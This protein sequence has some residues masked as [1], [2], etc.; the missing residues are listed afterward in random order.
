MIL[1]YLI[2]VQ[3]ARGLLPANNLMTTAQSLKT[4][5]V[6]VKAIRQG[7]LHLFDQI[8]RGDQEILVRWG[9][10][11]VVERARLLVVRQLFQKSHKILHSPSRLSLDILKKA[12]SV[13][14][15]SKTSD[16]DVSCLVVN[17]INKV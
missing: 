5:A 17:L 12:V 8:F 14:T 15:K 10:W 1:R 3:M 9:T 11:F 13:S 6:I 2:P 7:N 4:Y 16:E